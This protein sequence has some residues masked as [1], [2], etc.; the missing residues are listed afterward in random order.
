MDS[1]IITPELGGL[2]AHDQSKICNPIQDKHR[3]TNRQEQ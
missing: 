2:A 1:C 3:H